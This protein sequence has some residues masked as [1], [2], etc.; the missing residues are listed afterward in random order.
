MSH[1]YLYSTPQLCLNGHI[2][3]ME[4]RYESET[5]QKFCRRCGQPTISA[6]QNCG[7]PIKGIYLG[8]PGPG[9]W[10]SPS[11]CHECGE[12][13][14]WT[15]EKLKAVQEVVNEDPNLTDAEKGT[16]KESVNDLVR[17]TPRAP[18]AQKRYKMLAAKAGKETVKCLRE[19]FVDI[20][21]ETLKK[22]MSP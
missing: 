16:L 5:T 18:V 20:A 22:A 3:T 10:R 2:I 17:E 8:P 6:C 21:S 7:T 1:S 12:P 15:A 14:P 9:P 4:S 13:Y 11:F 19:L